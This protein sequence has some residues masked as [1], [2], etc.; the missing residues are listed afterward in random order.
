MKPLSDIQLRKI[1][2][3]AIS[4]FVSHSK[5]DYAHVSAIIESF[6]DFCKHNDYTIENGKIISNEKKEPIKT[7]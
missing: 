5:G 3:D 4:N 6:V 7:V 2:S 1:Q